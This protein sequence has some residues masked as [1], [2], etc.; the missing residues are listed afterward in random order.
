MAILAAPAWSADDTA[1]H[2][3]A[4]KTP[5]AKWKLETEKG[6]KQLSAGDAAAALHSFDEA[7]RLNPRAAAAK[8]GKGAVLSRQG[9]LRE[10]ER[11]LREA[12]TLNP[13]PTRTHYELGLIYQKRGDFEQAVTEFK[14][15]IEKYRENHPWLNR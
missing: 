15:G 5:V 10:A 7:L 12:L 1:A 11:L 13:D 4:G 2:P 6:Y 3:A 14:E 8:T 9:N